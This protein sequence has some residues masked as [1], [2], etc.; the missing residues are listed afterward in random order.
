MLVKKFDKSVRC[1]RGCDKAYIESYGRYNDPIPLEV[2]DCLEQF[3]THTLSRILNNFQCN[4]EPLR[5]DIY[6]EISSISKQE[7]ALRKIGL[8]K[9][10]ADKPQIGLS[11]LEADKP[12]STSYCTII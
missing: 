12:P 10:E 6:K 2:F 11:K 3:V 1:C 4:K 7:S 5:D 8:S 9:L